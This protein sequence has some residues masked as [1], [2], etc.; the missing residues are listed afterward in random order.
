MIT[1]TG[2]AWFSD[3]SDTIGLVT[4]D[5]GFGKKAYIRTVLGRDR[6]F[7]MEDVAKHGTP[8]PLEEAEAVIEKVGKKG[9][10]EITG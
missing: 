7:D 5:T 8:F 6:R 3:G 10:W 1:I 2:I 9:K 4:V